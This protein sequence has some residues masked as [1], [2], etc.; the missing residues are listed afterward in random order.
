MR[1][2]WRERLACSWLHEV[3]VSGAVSIKASTACVAQAFA[4]SLQKKKKP[5]ACLPVRYSILASKKTTGSGSRIAASSRP[6]EWEVGG[7]S[8][9]RHE[10]ARCAPY[11]HKLLTPAVHHWRQSTGPGHSAAHSCCLR[12]FRC[13]LRQTP[14]DQPTFGLSGTAGHDH[15]DAR[16]VG[17]EGF[18]RLGVVVAAV[19]HRPCKGIDVRV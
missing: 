3:A 12:T 4:S 5:A 15:F 1:L 18:W 7:D 6:E 11:L 13:M 10:S 17:E 2:H 9:V 16:D 19:P 8:K 14:T